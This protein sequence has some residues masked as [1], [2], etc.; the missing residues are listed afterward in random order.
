MP[1]SA[2]LFTVHD[3]PFQR[4]IITCSE[5]PVMLGWLVPTAKTSVAE[6]PATPVSIGTAPGVG[7]GTML[8]SLPLKCSIRVPPSKALLPPAVSPTAQISLAEMA[9]RELM[10]TLDALGS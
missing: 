6:R 3:L 2:A 7:L 9:V 10:L 4:R 5:P 1:R 8:Q